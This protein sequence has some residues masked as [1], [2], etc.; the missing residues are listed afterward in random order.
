MMRDVMN[1]RVAV[2]AARYTVIGTCFNYL[3]KFILAV[4]PA[5]LLEPR[6]EKT[7][8]AAATIIVGLVRRH[9]DDIFLAHYFFHD[10]AQVFCNSFAIAFPHYLA[11]ILDG[12]LDLALLVPVRVDL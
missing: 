5:L 12:E 2:V 6:L 7:T 11:G 1:L 4:S 9:F 8:A 10:V 3:I